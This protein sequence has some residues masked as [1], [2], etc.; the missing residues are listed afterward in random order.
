[1]NF[2]QNFT[3]CLQV[4][5]AGR[6]HEDSALTTL[7]RDTSLDENV[8]VHTPAGAP[9]VLHLIVVGTISPGTISNSENTVVEVRSTGASEDTRLVKL[10]GRLVGLNSN[11]HRLLNKSR[12]KSGVTVGLNISVGLDS[13]LRVVAR[14]MGLAVAILSSGAR[15]I[16]VVTLRAKT[17]VLLNPV[18]SVVHQTTIA[19]MVAEDAGVA[20]HKLLLRER[21]EG[22]ILDLVSA[23]KSTSGRERPA[24]AAVSL[25]LNRCDST[26]RFPVNTGRKGADISGGLMDGLSRRVVRLAKTKS[27]V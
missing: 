15:S 7:L 6:T 19:S 2:N 10:E 16:G 4:R 3:T 18:E 12:H 26:S 25:V 27:H 1:M 9:G 11:R 21:L 5:V 8:A 23:L 14:G 22:A 20:R 24:R 13:E 17:S